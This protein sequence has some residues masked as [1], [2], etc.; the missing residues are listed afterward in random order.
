MKNH[1]EDLRM[2]ANYITKELKQND[3]TEEDFSMIVTGILPCLIRNCR[4]LN[5][6]NDV[7]SIIEIGENK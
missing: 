7:K 5:I 3:L 6:I 4:E 1:K 2:I